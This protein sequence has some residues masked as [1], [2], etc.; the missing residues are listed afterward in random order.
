MRFFPKEV[1]TFEISSKASKAEEENPKKF[2][3]N[4]LDQLSNPRMQKE[5]EQ[6]H[7][8][9]DFKYTLDDFSFEF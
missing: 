7:L 1:R 8:N 4:A 6:N 2:I 5:F 3:P 9:N